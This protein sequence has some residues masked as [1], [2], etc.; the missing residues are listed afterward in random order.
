MMHSSL[1]VLVFVSA[2]LLI[3]ASTM[4]FGFSHWQLHHHLLLIPGA[5]FALLH[6]AAVASL[7]V[8][9]VHAKSLEFEFDCGVVDCVFFILQLNEAPT[10]FF[11]CLAEDLEY[12]H[13]ADGIGGHWVLTTYEKQWYKRDFGF[14]NWVYTYNAREIERMRT[15]HAQIK[16]FTWRLA[17][18]EGC[19]WLN[20]QTAKHDGWHKLAW[21]YDVNDDDGGLTQSTSPDPHASSSTMRWLE[22][23]VDSLVAACKLWSASGFC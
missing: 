20:V 14:G 6:R 15:K 12:H 22:P 13:G 7:V 21:R 9:H 18:F 11:Y 8:R 19:F 2:W 5:E 17:K 16:L 4:S 10:M 3:F 23:E 1:E